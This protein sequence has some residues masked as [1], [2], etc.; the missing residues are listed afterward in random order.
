MTVKKK[1]PALQLSE[2]QKE[3]PRFIDE[4]KFLTKKY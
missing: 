3:N 4:T 2:G 1:L